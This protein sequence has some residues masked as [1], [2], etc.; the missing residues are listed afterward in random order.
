MKKKHKFFAVF[1][2]LM[3]MVQ[4][5]CATVIEV[6]INDSRKGGFYLDALRLVLEKSGSKFKL[7]VQGDQPTSQA[8]KISQVI[9]GKTDIL[10]AGTSI[11]LEHKLLPIRFPIMRELAGLRL[12]IINK[13]HQVKFDAVKSLDDLSKYEGIQGFGWSDKEVLEAAGLKQHNA[14]Y[15][16]I[17]RMLNKGRPYYFPRAVT[18]IFT[19]VI[20]KKEEMP[21]LAVEK[22]I[23]LA[24]PSAIFFF[25]HPLNTK[26]ANILKSGFLNAYKDGSYNQFFYNHPMVKNA[27]AMADLNNRIKIEIPNPF[28]TKE[29]AAISKEY[30]H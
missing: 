11:K 20:S 18:E 29:T 26:L 12:F 25:V 15:D 6:R 22:N 10:Y 7:I 1:L 28:L 16:N 9:N 4:T 3:T 19:E 13:D 17:F 24:Y 23:I 5:V 27:I 14:L 30:S 21:N 8:R 2:L